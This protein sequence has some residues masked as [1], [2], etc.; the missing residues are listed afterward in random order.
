MT[1]LFEVTHEDI[2]QLNDVQLT[3]LLRRLLHLEAARFNIA[4][5]GISV[6]LNID[7]P[8][9]GEDGRI[10][11]K[12]GLKSTDYI[13]HRLTMFQNKAKAMGPKACADEMH[14]ER[15]ARLKPRIEEVLDA[16][17][18]YV[19]F[20]TQA[21][22]GDGISQRIGNMQEAIKEAGK[23][24]ADSAD[25]HIYDANGSAT[26]PTGISRQSRRYAYGAAVPC[27]S[28][29]KRGSTGAN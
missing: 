25:L 29:C 12:G 7:V 8:D 24:Y 20:T 3:D 9:G 26:G 5:R 14:Q 11:W 17:G 4:A 22:N 28:G 27:H 10:Q 16:R 2:K 1:Q 13:P 15:S 21:L 6:A 18:S 23:P 19:L